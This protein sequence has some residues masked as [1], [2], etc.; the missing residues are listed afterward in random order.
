MSAPGAP[1][2]MM[3]VVFFVT[4]LAVSLSVAWVQEDL[5]AAVAQLVPSL[6][7]A[8]VGAVVFVL[9]VRWWRDR[10]AE[11]PGSKGPK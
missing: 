10:Q 9:G 5:S 1:P 6:V 2:W 7:V 11:N 4:Y 3:G 8:G